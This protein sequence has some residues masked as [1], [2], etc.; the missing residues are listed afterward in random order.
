MTANTTTDDATD[1]GIETPVETTIGGCWND[2]ME[3]LAR[4]IKQSVGGEPDEIEV[5]D[6]KD[7][8]DI[9]WID[10]DSP[11]ETM[12][13]RLSSENLPAGV[14]VDS[15]YITSTRVSVVLDVPVLNYII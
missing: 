1:D 10:D 3:E 6:S 7:K 11:F 13:G 4:D 8:I 15:I 5:R 9:I 12:Y 14:S 2:E